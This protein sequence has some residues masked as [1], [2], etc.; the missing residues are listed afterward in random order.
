MSVYEMNVG[1]EPVYIRLRVPA[2]KK[3]F[4]QFIVREVTACEPADKNCIEVGSKELYQ[5]SVREKQS[6]SFSEYSLS[7]GAAGDVLLNT[8][9]VLF[10]AAAYKWRNRV[11]LFSAPSGTG[12]STQLMNWISLYPDEVEVINGDKPVVEFHDVIPYV[13][14]SPWTGKERMSGTESGVLAAIIYLEQ[15]KE[16]T[17]RRLSTQEAVYPVISQILMQAGSEEVILHAADMADKLISAVPVY[18]LINDGTLE[19]SRMTHDY[20]LEKEGAADAI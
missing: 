13:F 16:N 9:R 11:Y 10:H 7:T 5:F 20:L 17:I 6:L 8:G 3:Y 1:T 12:K 2:S 19:S 14:P 4:E 18:K 15:G